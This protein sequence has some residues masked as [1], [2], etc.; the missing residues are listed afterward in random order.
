MADKRADFE[1]KPEEFDTDSG[2]AKLERKK[3]TL[4][5]T[6]GD[7]DE[8][9]MRTSEL[10]QRKGTPS[11][12][13]TDDESE[14]DTQ[15]LRPAPKGDAGDDEPR[16]GTERVIKKKSLTMRTD[17]KRLARPGSTRPTDSKSMLRPKSLAGMSDSKRMLR[18]KSLAGMQEEEKIQT[19]DLLPHEMD[20]SRR[21]ETDTANLKRIRP[22]KT[23]AEG[24][25]TSGE[26]G[27]DTIHLRVIK[28]KKNQL[29][30]ILSASQTIRLRP[31]PSD[32]PSK[33]NQQTT[34]VSD[35]EKT[36][37]KDPSS[38]DDSQK[39]TLKIKSPGTGQ[40]ERRAGTAAMQR[41][42]PT[43]PTPEDE[44]KEDP[45]TMAVNRDALK[46]TQ[47]PTQL[48]RTGDTKTGTEKVR[49][50]TVKLKPPKKLDDGPADSKATL[51]IKAPPTATPPPAQGKTS[52]GTE[53][54]QK[55]TQPP[56]KAGTSKSTL[57]I[58]SPVQAGAQTQMSE[59]AQSK[60]SKSGDQTIK[61]QAPS[62]GKTLKLKA[63]PKQTLKAPAAAPT[64]TEGIDR[65]T[66]AEPA[67]V[68]QEDKA[69]T[70]TKT[71]DSPGI[72]FVV[73]SAAS[74]ALV[75]GTA[76]IS[77]MQFMSLYN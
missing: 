43:K 2:T 32:T 22:G 55:K 26:T 50:D 58:K 52:T 12:S 9:N 71:D 69:A 6:G 13:Q 27:T 42:T 60:Q 14:A 61:Q 56:S 34:I 7:D 48:K 3:V 35:G 74:L 33:A 24:V 18:P 63:A 75:A 45:R 1:G 70:V 5:P 19:Q 67:V 36:A 49:T 17:S 29:K 72:V 30:N 64:G 10:R 31:S 37:D 76:V 53:Q 40:E 46:S 20:P 23:S 57:K 39:R 77:I 73:C 15:D 8:E 21:R 4:R 11:A 59:P 25:T 28:E 16:A 54:V 38:S 47:V 44:T 68:P 41:K 51:K 65:E 66:T 62:G